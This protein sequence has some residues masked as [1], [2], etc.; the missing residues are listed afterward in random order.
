MFKYIHWLGQA[1]MGFSILF[2]ILKLMSIGEAIVTFVAGLVI[3]IFGKI[4]KKNTR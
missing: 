4:I 3:F 1:L 2:P